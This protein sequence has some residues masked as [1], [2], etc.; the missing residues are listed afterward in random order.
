[1]LTEADKARLRARMTGARPVHVAPRYDEP[2]TAPTYPPIAVV[3][4]P[5]EATRRAVDAVLARHGESR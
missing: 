4:L 2:T 1:M 5:S 3:V